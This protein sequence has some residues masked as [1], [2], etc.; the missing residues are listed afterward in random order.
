MFKSKTDDLD[1]YIS[2]I[3]AAPSTLSVR[4]ASTTRK[5]TRR[6]YTDSRHPTTE[7]PDVSADD[8]PDVTVVQKPLIRKRYE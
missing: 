2:Q 4:E 8:V 6:R 3:E 1:R 5:Y 7:L